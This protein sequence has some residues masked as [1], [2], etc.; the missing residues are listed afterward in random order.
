M[1]QITPTTDAP[2]DTRRVV[3]G[4][5]SAPAPAPI[6]SALAE[7]THVSLP[8]R[9]YAPDASGAT[10]RALVWRGANDVRVETVP[11]PG[12]TDDRDA[13]V[14]V[15]AT[16]ICG[17]D[18]HLYHNFITEMRAGDILGHEA[19]GII[20]QVGPNVKNLKPGDRVIVSAVIACGECNFC[21]EGKSSLCDTTNPS[22]SMEHLYGHRTAGLFGYSHLTG[23]LFLFFSFF[24]LFLFL[25]LGWRTMVT[26]S[27]L[28]KRRIRGWPS[29]FRSRPHCRSQLLQHLA[30]PAGQAAR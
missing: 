26:S 12:I 14:R 1:S 21:R 9:D 19:V 13:I 22:K 5:E 3:L 2:V 8:T 6:S 20:E 18:L 25:R 28:L 24:S 17:S 11:K 30:H 27:G 4:S 10:M 7:A 15:T 29:R 16:T 23:P